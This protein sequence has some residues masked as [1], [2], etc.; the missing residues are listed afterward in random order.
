MTTPR[1]TICKHPDRLAIEAAHVGG[2]AL[3]TIAAKYGCSRAA[4]HRHCAGHIG[5]GAH[6]AA[7]VEVELQ[8]LAAHIAGLLQVVGRIRAQVATR[9]AA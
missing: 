6:A 4:L 5:E 7:V 2:D 8:A 3:D 1:C 9:V